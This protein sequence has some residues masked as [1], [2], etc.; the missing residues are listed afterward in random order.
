MRPL[1]LLVLL[2]LAFALAQGQTP[3]NRAERLE[4]FRDAGF[5]L[6]IHWNM[7]VQLG[8]VISHSLVGASDDYVKRYYEELPKT[9]NPR[10][11]Y[12][13][14]WAVL[15]KLAGMRYV[16]FTAKHHNGFCM[17]DS[18]TTDFNIMHTPF[19]RDVTAEIF[20]A[21]RDQG[22]ATG[23]YFSPDDFWVLRQQGK[24]INRRSPGV[25]PSVNP[26][27]LAHDQAQLKE[28]LGNYGPI[29]VVYFDGD[30]KDLAKTVWDLQPDSVVTRGAIQTPE[31]SVPGMPL[32]GAWESS[33]SMGTAWQYQP[34]NETYKSGG[35]IINLLIETRAKGGNLLINVGPKPDGELPIEEEERLREVALWMFVNGD[36]IHSV[37][38]WV[39]TNEKDIW[40]TKKKDENTLY[41]IVKQIPKWQRGT[42][43]DIVLRSVRTTPQ[44]QV[45]VLGQNERAFEYVP[46]FVPKTTFHQEPDGLHIRAMHAYRLQ[47]NGQWP[48]PI[49]LKLTNV[50]PALK[51]PIVLTSDATR[52]AAGAVVFA[53]TLKDLGS[54]NSL[55]VGFEYRPVVGASIV[56]QQRTPWTTAGYV[57]RNE[58]GDFTIVSDGLAPER[59][60]EYRAVAKHPL[61]MIYGQQKQKVIK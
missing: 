3:A 29:A 19:H 16:V 32:E 20:K 36:A 46:K 48:N 1:R 54:E 40:F 50:E 44:T 43:R 45:T 2:V 42:W 8:T 55:E 14:D 18:A 12:P 47:D 59:I 23:V 28:L 51:P 57:R 7:D 15:A 17:W 37:R 49:V 10:K 30:A 4:W 9:F 58:S 24:L 53:G 5:G 25:D 33:I 56:E 41:A 61:L 60:Y 26:G 34:Q 39:I 38:P 52:N 13:Q 11:F 35:D 22:I 27:V 6:F 31:Q 21:F